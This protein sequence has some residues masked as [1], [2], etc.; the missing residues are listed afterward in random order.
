MNKSYRS[1]YRI[2]VQ[3]IEQHLA[4]PGGDRVEEMEKAERVFNILNK[5]T[6]RGK[7]PPMVCKFLDSLSELS[8]GLTIWLEGP[9]YLHEGRELRSK[10]FADVGLR[11]AL[12][13]AQPV[14]IRIRS[15]KG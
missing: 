5:R 6:R 12:L 11:I 7:K 8:H 15:R 14:L 13:V 3:D 10:V 4:G 2:F 1:Y 9:F